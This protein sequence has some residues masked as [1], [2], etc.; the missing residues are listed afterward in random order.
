[1]QK[2]KAIKVDGTYIITSNEEW[3]A[4]KPCYNGL[5]I[6]AATDSFKLGIATFYAI[7][8]FDV[9]E[10]WE[11]DV[12]ISNAFSINKNCCCHH[13]WI[14]FKEGYN[15]HAE[16]YKWTDED[17]RK[18]FLRDWSLN[19]INRNIDQKFMAFLQSLKQPKEYEVE[20]EMEEKHKKYEGVTVLETILIPKITNNKVKVLSWKEI[21]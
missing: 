19:D 2:Y 12:E 5:K 11:E 15:K 8:S 13:C 3:E 18:A 16:K 14:G 6:I 1:M 20:L 21:K 17:M 4:Y 9:P 10:E 7:P